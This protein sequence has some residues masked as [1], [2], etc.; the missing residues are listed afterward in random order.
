M[1]R[2]KV[3]TSVTSVT[4]SALPSTTAPLRSR[5][6]DTSLDTKRTVICVRAVAH[7]RRGNRRSIDRNKPRLGGFTATLAFS[8]GGVKTV[9]YFLRQQILE[10]TPVA[11]SEARYDHFVSG[12]RAGDEVL[13]VE[14]A[15]SRGDRIKPRGNRRTGFGN[16]L[17]PL[18]RQEPAVQQ[19][20]QAPDE[21]ARPAD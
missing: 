21:P 16:I 11:F 5:V 12:A 8:N 14:A 3:H 6:D 15:V 1:S 10:L 4:L 9:K 7:F 17:P 2:A 19:R 18:S 13:G 20:P